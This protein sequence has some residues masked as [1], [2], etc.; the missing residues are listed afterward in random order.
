MLSRGQ[1]PSLK[2]QNRS[3][4][5]VQRIRIAITTM[6]SI[7]NSFLP[8]SNIYSRLSVLPPHILT[9]ILSF[10]TVAFGLTPA[11]AMQGKNEVHLEQFDFLTASSGWILLDGHV[12]WSSDVGQ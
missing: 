5:L 12:F 10:I 9:I 2:R 4:Y 8:K 6:F 3:E 11:Q 7:S 1:E